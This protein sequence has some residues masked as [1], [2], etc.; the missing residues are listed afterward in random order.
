MADK[1]YDMKADYEGEYRTPPS[2]VKVWLESDRWM[3]DLWQKDLEW[4]EVI[5]QL[6]EHDTYRT[7]KVLNYLVDNGAEI[8]SINDVTTGGVCKGLVA[9][10][11]CRKFKLPKAKD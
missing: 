4:D 1:E 10:V 7:M 2:I 5:G 9:I 3:D 8:L 6:S 11:D